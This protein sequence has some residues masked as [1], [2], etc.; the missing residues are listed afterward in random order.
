[1]K[2]SL[3]VAVVIV[4]LCL[5]SCKD[6]TVLL[7]PVINETADVAIEETLC[8]SIS[9]RIDGE[10]GAE[11]GKEE[12]M[13]TSGM[14]EVTYKYA[15]EWEK[16]AGEYRDKILILAEEHFPD[17][18]NEFEE[19]LDKLKQSY[20]EYSENYLDVYREIY[21]LHHGEGSIRGILYASDYYELKKKYAIEIIRIYEQLQCLKNN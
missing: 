16:V 5:C 18:R 8:D 6:K 1:M 13:T 19:K 7:D 2:K 11:L 4:M 12:N 9:K 17:R 3:V 15:G 10:L 21:N 20:D 14:K